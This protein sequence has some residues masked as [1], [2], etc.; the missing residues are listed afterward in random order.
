L[1]PMLSALHDDVALPAALARR[2]I[3]L[4]NLPAANFMYVFK[5]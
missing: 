2:R 5:G 1:K 3:D 4:L